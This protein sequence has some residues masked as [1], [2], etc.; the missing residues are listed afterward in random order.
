VRKHQQS[1]VHVARFVKKA[2]A[3]SFAVAGVLERSLAAASG[4]GNMKM[5]FELNKLWR[6]EQSST[7]VRGAEVPSMAMS[8]TTM[9]ETSS[10][11]IV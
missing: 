4:D 1:G 5:L 10:D 8:R 3:G 11:Q 6:I 9:A 2:G 7:R